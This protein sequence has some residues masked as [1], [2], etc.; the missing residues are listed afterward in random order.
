MIDRI[1]HIVWSVTADGH[2]DYFNSAWQHLTGSGAG[3]DLETAMLQRIFPDDRQRWRDC[4]RTTLKTG[5]SSDVEYRLQV[6]S[7]VAPLW[8]LERATAVRNGNSSAPQTWLATATLINDEM[9]REQELRSRLH[10]RDQFL[11]TLLHELRN[12]LAPIANAL[13]LL[14]AGSSDPLVV[15]V[16]RGIIQRQLRQLTRLVDDLFDVSRLAHGSLALQCRL[17]DLADVVSTAVEAGRPIMKVREQT[18]TISSTPEPIVLEADPVRLGQVFTNLLINAAKYTPPGGHISLDTRIENGFV[19]VRVRDD[20]IGIA[21]DKLSRI[22]ELFAQAAPGS[23]ASAAGLGVGLAVAKQL[24]ELH[25][26]EISVRSEGRGRGS[27]FT[28]RLPLRPRSA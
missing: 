14:G 27:E 22:F 13:D 19:V 9:A 4:W 2:V 28:V 5:K 8:Y 11:A 25:G 15:N 18:F 7:Q 26:G 17:I 10:T 16:A 20:G 23:A 1:P 6:Q 3:A 21:A 12:P 24:V